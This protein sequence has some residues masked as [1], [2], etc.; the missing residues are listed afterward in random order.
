[1]LIHKGP[2]CSSRFTKLLTATQRCSCHLKNMASLEQRPC[3]TRW[4]PLKGARHRLIGHN[5]CDSQLFFGLGHFQ[6][7]SNGQSTGSEAN[8]FLAFLENNP[9]VMDMLRSGYTLRGS[10]SGFSVD[11][12]F[13]SSTIWKVSLRLSR[14]CQ[15]VAIP[16]PIQKIIML[17]PDQ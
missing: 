13:S 9:K 15:M 5:S 8:G 14:P 2:P 12:L 4:V 11:F 10:R 3:A 17:T 6:G 16:G 7:K 1:M